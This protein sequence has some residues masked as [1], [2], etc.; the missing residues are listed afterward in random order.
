MLIGAFYLMIKSKKRFSKTVHSVLKYGN[1]YLGFLEVEG[2]ENLK[3]KY[4][5]SV[6]SSTLYSNATCG[7]PKDDYFNIL[8]SIKSDYPWYVFSLHFLPH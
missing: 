4:S 2:F 5:Y 6:P 3:T 8:R 1:L 7:L